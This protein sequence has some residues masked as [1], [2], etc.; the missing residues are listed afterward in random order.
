MPVD[1]TQNMKTLAGIDPAHNLIEV[2]ADGKINKV[3]A[4]GRLWRTLQAFLG[5]GRGFQDCKFDHV[6]AKL[7]QMIDTHFDEL[8]KM[9]PNA[10]KS[11]TEALRHLA[12]KKSSD[13]SLDG[14]RDLLYEA[15]WPTAFASH[16]FYRAVLDKPLEG[17]ERMSLIQALASTVARGAF[18]AAKNLARAL[19]KDDKPLS[20][21]LQQILLIVAL[22][23][24]DE[25]LKKLI[26]DKITV[27]PLITSSYDLGR[28]MVSNELDENGGLG[29]LSDPLVAPHDLGQSLGKALMRALEKHW[30]ELPPDLLEIQGSAYDT[31]YQEVVDDAMGAGCP[32]LAD[33]AF[34]KIMGIERQALRIEYLLGQLPVLSSEAQTQLFAWMKDSRDL[35]GAVLTMIE[36]TG[37]AD[38]VAQVRELANPPS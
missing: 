5:V 29:G 3:T 21:N 11:I 30:G 12:W 7:S 33:Y 23:G 13:R 26:L 31:Y 8:K 37:A 25:E 38:V 2:T 27:R 20:R 24:G 34:K 19:L 16:A 36:R 17:F 1:F 32:K 28:V 35:A 15:A 4:L 6:A 10:Q 22:E 18:S 14:I 9:D